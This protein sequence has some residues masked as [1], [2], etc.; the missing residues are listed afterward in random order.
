MVGFFVGLTGGLHRYFMGDFT[1]LA[2]MISTTAEGLLAGL[3]M[4]NAVGGALFMSMI[5]QIVY[6]ETGV[7]AVSITDCNK[8]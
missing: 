6:E 1:D 5:A 3:P 7:G 8:F 2:C 4:T